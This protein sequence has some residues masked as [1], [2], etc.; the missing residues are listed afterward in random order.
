MTLS[1]DGKHSVSVT[2]D[3]PAAVTEGLVW[4]K[5]THE[6]LVRFERTHTQAAKDGGGSASQF[7][8]KAR[9]GE[10]P[11]QQEETPVCQIHDLP[12]VKVL[13]SGV[14]SGV[15]TRRTRMEVGAPIGP[16]TNNS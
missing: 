14:S 2:S 11:R 6:Q 15:A 8:E 10:Q 3:D 12:M 5:R 16:I 4:A 13:G 9:D 1:I 7:V